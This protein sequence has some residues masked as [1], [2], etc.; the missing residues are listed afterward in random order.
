[1]DLAK[2]ADNDLLYDTDLRHKKNPFIAGLDTAV[3]PG[4][5]YIADAENSRFMVVSDSGKSIAQAGF[6]EYKKVDKA[7][8]LKLYLGGVKLFKQL[9]TAGSKVFEILYYVVMDNHDKDRIYLAYD[10]QFM[11][12][13]QI[14]DR[15]WLR[16]I[17]ELLEKGFIAKTSAKHFYYLNPDYIWNG[18]R[19]NFIS[20]I[21]STAKENDE[22]FRSLLRSTVDQNTGEVVLTEIDDENL[23]INPKNKYLNNPFILDVSNNTVRGVRRV[24]D[25]SNNRFMLL[26]EHGDFVAQAGFWQFKQVDK[27]QFVKLFVNGVK[28]FK[29]LSSAGTRVFEIF[30]IY[31]QN[32]QNRDTLYLSYH[33]IAGEH[34]ISQPTWNRGLNE[35]LEKGFIAKAETLHVFYL[36]PDY[37]WNGDRL[38]LIRKYEN[39][40]IE[41]KRKMNQF[42]ELQYK[43]L[44]EG[45]LV[46]DEIH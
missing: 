8:F 36:N 21:Q 27:T 34:D 42:L 22:E 20:R 32:H 2:I 18:D 46:E 5:R 37:M 26:N 33:T 16:G 3:V 29:H 25:K 9:S 10:K 23:V 1:M 24:V 28:L 39:S 44:E 35:L 45:G 43:K 41:N 4:V 19:L 31:I 15:H 11:E 40:D 13:Y 6:W 38:D 7:Q 30:Y 12:R 17:A 14:S